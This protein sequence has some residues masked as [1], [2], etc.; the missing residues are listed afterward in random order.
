M[1]DEVKKTL[2][3]EGVEIT[4]IKNNVI[5]INHNPN[6]SGLLYAFLD[7]GHQATYGG[8]KLIVSKDGRTFI[9]KQQLEN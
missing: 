4:S 2:E 6:S 9:I 1:L 5:R 7:D 3:L 8:G